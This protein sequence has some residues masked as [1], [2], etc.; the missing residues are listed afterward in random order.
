MKIAFDLHN[1]SCLSPCASLEMSPR[2][3]AARAAK[4]G[5]GILGLTDHNCA[6]NCPAMEEACREA[7]LAFIPGIEVTT[8]EECHLLCLFPDVSTALGFGQEIGKLQP[9]IGYD[10]E[11]LGDQVYVDVEGNI[12]GE[13]EHYLGVAVGL[14]I[15]DIAALAISSGGAAIPAHIDRARFSVRSQLGFLPEGP[16]SAVETVRIPPEG[17][18]PLRYPVIVDSDAHFLESMGRRVTI[19]DADPGWDGPDSGNAFRAFLAAAR[20][21]EFEYRITPSR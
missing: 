9:A 19:F 10:P 4:L 1:H 2:A 8:M 14:S 21:G 13:V 20:K 17:I 5:I 12:L 11:K 18:D 6:L 16:W 7:G 15:E 3:M